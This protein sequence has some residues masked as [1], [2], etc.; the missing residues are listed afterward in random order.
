[1]TELLNFGVRQ[2]LF[3]RNSSN[4]LK[5]EVVKAWKTAVAGVQA[6]FRIKLEFPTCVS[7]FFGAILEL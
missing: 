4:P 1:M 7:M 3:L 5:C 2:L 6:G